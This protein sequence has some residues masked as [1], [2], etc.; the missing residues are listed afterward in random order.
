MIGKVCRRGTDTR[1]LLGYLFTEGLAGERGLESAHVDARVIAGYQSAGALEPQRWPERRPDARADVSRLAALLDA[2]VRAGGV[3]KDAKATYHLAIS[4]APT[5]RLLTDAEWADIAELYV[6]RL[7]LAKRGDDDAVRWVAVRHAD[8]HVHVVATLVRQ[9][10]RRVFPHHDF[11]RAREASLEVERTFRLT[12]TSPVDRT[13]TPKTTRAE[14]RK[15]RMAVGESVRAGLPTPVGPDREVLRARVRAALAGSDGWEDFAG[16]LRLSGVLVRERYSTRNPGQLSGYAVG[17]LATGARDAPEQ[18]VVWFGGGK[19]A[20]DLSLPQLRARWD[21]DE[22]ASGGQP[23]RQPGAGPTGRPHRARS[24]SAPTQPAADLSELERRRLWV[25]AENAVH[26]ADADM[27]HATSHPFDASAQATAQAAA[28]SAGEVLGAVSWLV[29]RKRGGPLHAAAEDYGRA[30][31][32]L[33]RRTVPAT[34]HS[35]STRTAAGALVGSRLVKRAETRQLLS[36]LV[37]LTALSDSLARLRETQGRAAQ[38]LAAR[39]AAE[40]LAGEHLRRGGGRRVIGRVQ[41]RDAG[42]GEHRARA[43]T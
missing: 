43:A 39:R 30:A 24:T 9:D 12:P 1:R 18:Q 19:L 34:A 41:C 21:Q 26:R 11:Y 28:A 23:G 22:G 31:R 36:L 14:Q 27:R 10:G 7:G 3:G 29:E 35:R 42:S 15:H 20:P 6:D 25:G 4:A 8:N 2:P 5:D 16:R 37:R 32:D 40:Q 13:A 33:H 17:L 38:A